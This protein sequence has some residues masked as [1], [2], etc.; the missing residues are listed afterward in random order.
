MAA[1]SDSE[2]S[3]RDWNGRNT[4][5]V[6]PRASTSACREA[7]RRR[8]R[9]SRRARRVRPQQVGR[10]DH[11]VEV[12]REPHVARVHA[13]NRSPH[14]Y[15]SRKADGRSR[16]AT[17]PS[18]QS[19]IVTMRSG[20]RRDRAGAD[21]CR[22]RS[23]PRDRRP[24]A[25]RA[26]RPQALDRSRIPAPRAARPPRGTDPSPPARTGC[27]GLGRCGADQADRWRV[28]QGDDHVG[29]SESRRDRA[30]QVG[31]VVREATRH[32]GGTIE[33]RR[34]HARDANSAVRSRETRPRE[35]VSC[36]AL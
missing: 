34:P 2:R 9:R 1:P 26:R 16:G 24:R 35:P 23:R 3:S 25:A 12:L 4:T 10:G 32:A 28:G 13:T 22:D 29:S 18:L 20:A 33:R 30:R 31:G 27:A 6:S 8:R 36:A 14:P 17:R 11:G 21:P 7:S 5:L 15:R 19:W